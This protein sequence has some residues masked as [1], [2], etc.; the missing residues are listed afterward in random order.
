MLFS[1]T[2][3]T[4][5]GQTP[6]PAMPLQ[7]AFDYGFDAV[8]REREVQCGDTPAASEDGQL[9]MS[10]FMEQSDSAVIGLEEDAE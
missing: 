6:A 8:K 5:R 10:E 3:Q 7:P 4:T 9:G 1:I 2:R